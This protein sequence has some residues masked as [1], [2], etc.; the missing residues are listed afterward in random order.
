MH[1]ATFDYNQLNLAFKKC[2]TWKSCKWNSCGGTS[3]EI[4]LLILYLK[5]LG[6]RNNVPDVAFES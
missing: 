2:I 4:N 6:K 5:N 1:R 3:S